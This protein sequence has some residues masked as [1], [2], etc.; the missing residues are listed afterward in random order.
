MRSP[1]TPTT[2]ANA[3]WNRATRSI[4]DKAG[5]SLTAG[6]YALHATSNQRAVITVNSAVSNT[7]AI[8]T[9]T[10]TRT[11]LDYLGQKTHATSGLDTASV[12]LTLTSSIV[13]TA[14]SDGVGTNT[15][16]ASFEIEETY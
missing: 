4:T 15:V 13:V 11:S 10:V 12:Y 3:I 14:T 1:F 8:S 5:F 9:V 16:V 6:S 7:A 2:L